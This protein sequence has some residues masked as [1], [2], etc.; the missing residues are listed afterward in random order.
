MI[1][2]LGAAYTG[3]AIGVIFGAIVATLT[4]YSVFTISLGGIDQANFLGIQD[5]LTEKLS[6]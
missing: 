1:K 2:K 6:E 3:F 4:S 5:C